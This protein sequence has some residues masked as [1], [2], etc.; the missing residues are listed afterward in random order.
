MPCFTSNVHRRPVLW[1]GVQAI[2]VA[3]QGCVPQ[4]VS[5]GE[6][7]QAASAKMTLAD[8]KDAIMS[9]IFDDPYY[10]ERDGHPVIQF[11]QNKLFLKYFGGAD[12]CPYQDLIPTS[13]SSHPD[14]IGVKC[15][16]DGVMYMGVDKSLKKALWRWKTSTPEERKAFFSGKQY[17]QFEPIA[18][19]YRASNPK[20]AVTEEIRRFQVMAVDAVREKH[21]GVAADDYLNALKITPWWPQGHFNAALLLAQIQY[22]GEAIEH[23]KKYLML[24]P[25]APNARAAQDQIYRWQSEAQVAAPEQ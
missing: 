17:E 23:M 4:A 22:Y 7:D 5:A 1:F 11:G 13:S 25:D 6:V 16:A 15:N 14:S 19:R 20:P 24:V 3:L 18:S 9:D 12:S 21:F 10:T 8:A 2:V